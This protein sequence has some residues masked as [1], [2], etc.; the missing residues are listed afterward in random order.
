VQI[1]A[2]EE[3]IENEK[4]KV[5]NNSCFVGSLVGVLM[6]RSN[7]CFSFYNIGLVQDGEKIILLEN[8]V[9]RNSQEKNEKK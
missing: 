3:E 1:K 9:R 8:V 2:E 5:Q 4:I 6:F 7:F